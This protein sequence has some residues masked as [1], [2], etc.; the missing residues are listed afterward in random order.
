ML[1]ACLLHATGRVTSAARYVVAI[2]VLYTQHCLPISG[3]FRG[4]Q[5]AAGRH[6]TDPS[7]IQHLRALANQYTVMTKSVNELKLLRGLDTGEKLDPRDKIR[8]TA[9]RVGLS[10]PRVCS[11]NF[12]L[13]DLGC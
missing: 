13:R 3:L 5:F 10:V 6:E 7:K 12:L 2:S 11:Y 9:R 4:N 1:K 8:A